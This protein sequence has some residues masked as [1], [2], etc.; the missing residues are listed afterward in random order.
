MGKILGLG[1]E[2]VPIIGYASVSSHDQKNDLV[3]QQELLEWKHGY[4]SREAKVERSRVRA[5]ILALRYLRDSISIYLAGQTG[6]GANSL[7]ETRAKYRGKPQG[8][9]VG[10]NHLNSSVRTREYL[11]TAEIERGHH[12]D[13]A[14]PF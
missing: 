5:A 6:I 7:C 2:D 1:S 10:T 13:L 11:T 12:N 4:Y 14:L 8:R 9:L 3:R